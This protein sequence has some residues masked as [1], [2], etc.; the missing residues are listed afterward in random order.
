MV[1]YVLRANFRQDVSIDQ[2]EAGIRLPVDGIMKDS[3]DL[4][5]STNA[6]DGPVEMLRIEN[7]P[8]VGALLDLALAFDPP[9]AATVASIHLRFRPSMQ[10]EEYDAIEVHLPSFDGPE[11]GVI[12]GNQI[13]NLNNA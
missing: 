8:S 10:M 12:D 3:P 2:D 7:N 11:F 13:L 6:E 5:I 1:K 9:K 4:T